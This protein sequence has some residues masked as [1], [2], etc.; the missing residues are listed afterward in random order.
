M[1]LFRKKLIL[2]AIIIVAIFISSGIY[3]YFNIS[4][5]K[6]NLTYDLH[7]FHNYS[8]KLQISTFVF[9]LSLNEFSVANNK[10]TYNK[11]Q[12]NFDLLYLRYEILE[13]YDKRF[14]LGFQ[15]KFNKLEKNL[16]SIDK[17]LKKDIKQ[18]Y[19]KIPT[20]Q[21]KIDSIIIDSNSIT[22]DIEVFAK[23]SISNLYN[24]L[25]SEAIKVLIFFTIFLEY[26]N[27]R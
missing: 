2:S 6:E 23:K 17:I 19:K 11:I 9:E 24:N 16:V 4:K 7:Q 21:L 26:S 5:I 20:V 15:K 18:V 1:F 12:Q 10:L 14:S 22:T 8:M 27:S 13:K 3:F 25:E